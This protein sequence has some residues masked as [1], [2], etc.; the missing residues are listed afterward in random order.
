MSKLEQENS[1]EKD[2]NERD[3]MGQTEQKKWGG[4]G[5]NR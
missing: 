1:K 3:Q 4:G 2:G 5:R